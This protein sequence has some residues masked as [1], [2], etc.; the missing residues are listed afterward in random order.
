MMRVP[1]QIVWLREMGGQKAR[2]GVKF[3]ETNPYLQ[4]VVKEF[5]QTL[6]IE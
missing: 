6:A 5:V 2:L 4:R 3:T 1:G